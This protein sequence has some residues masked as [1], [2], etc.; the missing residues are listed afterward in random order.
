M[1]LRMNIGEIVF[2]AIIYENIRVIE[3]KSD[4]TC[5]SSAS[6]SVGYTTRYRY[7]IC[8]VENIFCV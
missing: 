8:K 1:V 7:A 6:L 5:V 3:F 4:D 2:A